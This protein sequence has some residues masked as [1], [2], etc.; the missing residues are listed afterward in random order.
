M[1]ALDDATRSRI[2]DVLGD[3]EIAAA[4]TP[5]DIGQHA[6]VAVSKITDILDEPA[7]PPTEDER[8]ALTART[9]FAESNRLTAPSTDAQVEAATRT[10]WVEFGVVP[11]DVID[12]EAYTAMRAALEAARTEV[13]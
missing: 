11:G 4:T 12:P 2:E 7:T 10:F 6:R 5:G 1:T 9:I 3:Y 8:E 13:S